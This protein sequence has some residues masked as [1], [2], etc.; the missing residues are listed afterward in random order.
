MVHAMQQI[1]VPR[2]AV[3]FAQLGD[4]VHA[5][6]VLLLLR[7]AVLCAGRL[8]GGEVIDYFFFRLAFRVPGYSI[9][10]E[11]VIATAH[12]PDCEKTTDFPVVS[13]VEERMLLDRRVK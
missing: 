11:I 8:K 7:R 4:A 10:H 9:R 1:E 2:L 6:V 13:N 5:G 12:P 3:A